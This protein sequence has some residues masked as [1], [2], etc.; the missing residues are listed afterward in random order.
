MPEEG[1]S[2]VDQ[3]LWFKEGEISALVSIILYA[4]GCQTFW[5]QDLFIL[6]KI[7]K[8]PKELRL[9][10]FRRHK[11]PHACIWLPVRVMMAI[12]DI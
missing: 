10:Y 1:V 11:D 8:D 4:N 5:S 7:N 12:G 9:E 3:S 6:L 2:Q